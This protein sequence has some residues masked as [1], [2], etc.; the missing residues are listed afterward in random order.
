MIG[1]ESSAEDTSVPPLKNRLR[2][3]LNEGRKFTEIP[4]MPRPKKRFPDMDPGMM[5]PKPPLSPDATDLNPHQDINPLQTMEFRDMNG[6][7]IEDRAEGIYR[8]RDLIP[9]DPNREF[10]NLQ[11]MFDTSERLSEVVG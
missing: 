7:G 8:D 10:R 6:N 9:Y 3:L 11:K 5:I 2:D 1:I 4:R